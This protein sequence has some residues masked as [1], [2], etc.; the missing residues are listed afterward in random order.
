M[1][2]FF[3]TR[4]SAHARVERVTD[5]LSNACME[6]KTCDERIMHGDRAR[7]LGIIFLRRTHQAVF[8]GVLVVPNGSR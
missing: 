6:T 5:A 4:S 8:Y 2:D 3:I 1:H 7:M